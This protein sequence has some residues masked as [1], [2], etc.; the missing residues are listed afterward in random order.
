MAIHLNTCISKPNKSIEFTSIYQKC[1]FSFLIFA[2]G[3]SGC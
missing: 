2:G 3:E 1:I